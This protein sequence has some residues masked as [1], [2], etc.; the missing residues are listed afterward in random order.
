MVHSASVKPSD[1]QLNASNQIWRE[2]H[3]RYLLQGD[4]TVLK[5]I[6]NFTL[7]YAKFV[8]HSDMPYSDYIQ[9]CVESVI[10]L[11]KVVEVEA[12]GRNIFHPIALLGRP[13]LVRLQLIEST[14]KFRGD[15]TM[16]SRCAILDIKNDFIDA[17]NLANEPWEDGWR[18]MKNFRRSRRFKDLLERT[19]THQTILTVSSFSSYI[20]NPYLTL[21]LC[22]QPHCNK[23]WP[24]R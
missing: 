2:A 10:A 17:K 3:N 7:E 19:S 20:C 6:Y 9:P 18:S 12:P 13:V 16:S 1:A 24:G 14:C 11:V 15:M 4:C 22:R 23:L 5:D 21:Y 8:G